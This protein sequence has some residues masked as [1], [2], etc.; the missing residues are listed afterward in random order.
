MRW[1]VSLQ[2]PA[3]GESF[4]VQAQKGNIDV[5]L[6]NMASSSSFAPPKL[7]DFILTE[8]LGSG[9]YATVYKA[10]R[11]VGFSQHHSTLALHMTFGS[12]F[13]A[14]LTQLFSMWKRWTLSFGSWLSPCRETA[15]KS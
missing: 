13:F 7:A 10:Y 5:P 14:W 3:D 12:H 8:R 9:S 6:I 4:Y 15:E 1:D 2:R 11:K